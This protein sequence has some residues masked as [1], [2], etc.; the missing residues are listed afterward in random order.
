M[1]NNN[2]L[3]LLNSEATRDD[4]KDGISER[5]SKIQSLANYILADA[6]NGNAN[7]SNETLLNAIWTIESLSQEV[8]TLLTLL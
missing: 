4:L 5:I 6:A 8:D 2:N 3:F 7:V 1:K